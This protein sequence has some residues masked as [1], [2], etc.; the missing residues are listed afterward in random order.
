MLGGMKPLLQLELRKG[1]REVLEAR[2]NSRTLPTR[3]VLRA[4][5][6]LARADGLSKKQTA[7]QLR[8]SEVTVQRWT[9]RYRLS[10]LDGLRDRPGRGRKPRLPVEVRRRIVEEAT[11]PPPGKTRH[12]TRTMARMLGVSNSYVHG[13]WRSNDL[14]P[15]LTRTFKVSTDPHF[16]AKFWDIIGLYLAPPEE[17]VV[18]CCDEKTQCQALERTQPCL[19][20]GIGHIRTRTHD[21]VRN[22]TTTLFAALDYATGKVLHRTEAAHTH[23]EWLAFLRQID[24]ATPEGLDIHVIADNYATHKHEAVKKWLGR[25]K[26]FH[27]HYTPTSSSWMNLVERFF[28]EITRECIRDGSFASVRELEAAIDEHIRRRNE[29]PT[30]FV[31]KAEGMAILAK[32]NRAKDKL[33]QP[34]LDLAQPSKDN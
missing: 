27:M 18:F 16:R 12:S 28:G 3:D 25:H 33:G 6:V 10:G 4:G 22:G 23:K 1:D 24:R 19:P 13:I 29:A 7:S 17:A 34:L 32:I 21:Y 15:H 5:I 8:T 20:L 14:K 11:T 2:R 26:R 30:R 9:D 31:W